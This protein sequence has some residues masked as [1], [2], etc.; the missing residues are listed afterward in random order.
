VVN[1]TLVYAGGSFTSIGSQPRNQIAALDA[2]TGLAT[3]WNPNVATSL[4]T[5]VNAILVSGVS[6]VQVGGPPSRGQARSNL[7]ALDAS[8]GIP[9]SWNQ[10]LTRSY[11]RWP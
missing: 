8:S 6:H 1:G 7:A 3:G 10:E 4:N 11:R 2:A 5:S 9:T